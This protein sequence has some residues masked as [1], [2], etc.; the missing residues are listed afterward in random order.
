MPALLPIAA[1]L[2]MPALLP[3]AAFSLMTQLPPGF[4]ARAL[5]LNDL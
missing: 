3:I 2:L 5:W 1:F 4:S